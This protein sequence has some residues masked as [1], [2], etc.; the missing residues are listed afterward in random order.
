[1]RK[2]EEYK[3]SGV[4]W[5]KKV[6]SHW[7]I[8][9]IKRSLIL[10]TDYDAN[11]SFSDIGKN[12]NRVSDDTKYAWFVRT[13]DLEKFY[14]DVNLDNFVWIDEK[15]F[16]YL[17]KS[18]I[19]TDDLLLAKRGDIGKIYLMPKV[20]IPV[21]LA[22]N[23]YLARLNNKHITS[24]YA[25]FFLITDFGQRQLNLR[26]KS[27]TLGALYKDDFKSLEFPFPPLIEQQ[28]I[29]NY[30]DTK[31]QAIDKKITLLEQK[32]ETY[33]KLKRTFITQTITGGLYKN[34]PFKESGIP[35]IKQIPQH[36]EVKRFKDVVRKYTT[37]GTPST[38]NR[39]YFEGDNVW[40]SIGDMGDSKYIDDSSMYL[41]DEA[42]KDAN[43]IKTPKGSLLYSF[44]LSIGK[45]A[46]TMKDV[47]TNEAILSIFPN[48]NIDLEY[49]YYMLD[50][51]MELAATEN[52]YG[53][54]M[55]NQKLI[56]NALVI[57]PP[58]SEQEGIAK[59][60]DKKTTTIDAIIDNIVKQIE[61]LKQLRKT[62]INDVVTGKI[63]VIE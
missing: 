41:T 17:K 62:L 63:K 52:I 16:N 23:L 14:E 29:T 6:P 19:Y 47:Y 33:K 34:V 28:A 57:H 53:A 31:T 22:P 3:D 55:L 39:G 30:L 12:V 38:S 42:I 58:K 44:K 56:A 61:T 9:Q 48:I 54:K 40:I 2:Y 49:Y 15:S 8:N 21:S 59:Y 26:N 18:K 13:T 5:I 43:I 20:D 45:M 27:T 7:L 11:G 1:M 37:G 51:C 36:W 24:R 4:D 50:I 35:W 25:Y 60:L 10:L 46:F 32:I